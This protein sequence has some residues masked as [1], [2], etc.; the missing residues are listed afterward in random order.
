MKNHK[1]RKQE[2][3]LSKYTNIRTKY[4]MY[5]EKILSMKINNSNMDIFM[6]IF[7]KLR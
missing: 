1:R 3:K 4:K 7:V 5:L 6:L 2:I